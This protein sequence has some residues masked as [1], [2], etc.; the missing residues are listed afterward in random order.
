[1]QCTIGYLE[2][3]DPL[4]DDSGW[5]CES[6]AASVPAAFPERVTDQAAQTVA[7]MEMAASGSAVETCEKFLLV[8]SRVLH[9][10]HAHMVDVGHTLLHTLGHSEVRRDCT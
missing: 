5:T 2:P 6:C 10:Q 1:M 4:D 3:D 8:H 9:P 7:L